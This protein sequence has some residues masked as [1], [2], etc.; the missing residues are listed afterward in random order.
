MCLKIWRGIS[1]KMS[2]KSKFKIRWPGSRG[3]RAVVA[4]WAAFQGPGRRKAGREAWSEAAV[5]HTS[6]I[7]SLCQV[8]G[9]QDPPVCGDELTVVKKSLGFGIREM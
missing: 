2:H 4:F 5:R 9:P 6:L 7:D 1:E 3:L 8:L